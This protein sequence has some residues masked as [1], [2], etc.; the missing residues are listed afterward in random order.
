MLLTGGAHD[1]VVYMSM[2]IY[3]VVLLT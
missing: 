1:T 2:S 3:Q